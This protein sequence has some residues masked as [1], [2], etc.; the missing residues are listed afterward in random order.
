MSLASMMA[1]SSSTS[2]TSRAPAA[3]SGGRS[4][5]SRLENLQYAVRGSS[6]PEVLSAFLHHSRSAILALPENQRGHCEIE[7]RLGLVAQPWGAPDRR[8]FSSYSSSLTEPCYVVNYAS[9]DPKTQSKQPV[10]ADVNPDPASNFVSGISKEHLSKS[11]CADPPSLFS[12]VSASPPPAAP[13]PLSKSLGLPP[14]PG[15]GE[16]GGVRTEAQAEDV[17]CELNKNNSKRYIVE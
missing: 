5:S 1:K 10:Y 13:S 15:G 2:S 6:P 14:D 8:L 3:S 16:A 12:Q 9:S 7:A 11:T 17:Y 4:G